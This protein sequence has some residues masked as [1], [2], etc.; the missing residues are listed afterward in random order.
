MGHLAAIE[1]HDVLLE[2]S[3]GTGMLAQ[4]LGA[5]KGCTSTKSILRALRR[6]PLC[7]RKPP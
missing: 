2:P 5:G 7:S 6:L 1:E 3:A 4:W